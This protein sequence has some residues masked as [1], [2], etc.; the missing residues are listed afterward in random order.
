[1]RPDSQDTSSR[2]VEVLAEMTRAALGLSDIERVNGWCGV[3]ARLERRERPRTRRLAWAFGALTLC[4]AGALAAVLLLPPRESAL[5]LKV[6][7]G[8]LAENGHVAAAPGGEAALEFS[9]GT[10][11]VLEQ[12]T[13]ARVGSVGPHG[14]TIVIEHGHVRVGVEPRPAARWVLDA[15]PFR[16]EVKGTVF[17]VDWQPET[18]RLLV[19]LDRGVV[20]VSGPSLA[21]PIVLRGHQSITVDA[22]AGEATIRDS[23]IQP[24]APAAPAPVE[25][26]APATP[27]PAAPSAVHASRSR[28]SAHPAW[29]ALLAAGKLQQILA[30][31]ERIG[32]ET[33]LAHHGSADLAAL[34]DAARYGSRHDI[35]RRAL[36]A[37]RTRFAGSAHA[38]EAAFLLGRI[39]E[40]SEGGDNEALRW[41]D[42]YLHEAASGP[43]AAEVLGRKMAIIQRSQGN[44]K[45]EP[46]AEEYLRRYPAGSYA[47]LARKLLRATRP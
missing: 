20:R 32:M 22:R 44:A 16:V 37:Q 24:V 2:D 43:Y 31:A 46:V 17:E 38:S 45:A 25:A 8:T 13:L 1:M 10:R 27:V 5:S 40:A 41:Y 15:G 19:D 29:P 28:S 3:Q 18:G 6:R 14:A 11:V 26:P 30:D 33:V 9:D 42:R 34:A 39:D 36:L 12:G 7:G 4:G 47:E 23:G 35:A 21:E